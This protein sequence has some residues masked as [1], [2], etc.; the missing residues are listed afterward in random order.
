[1]LG[2]LT[3]SLILL[4]K[5]VGPIFYKITNYTIDIAIL[6]PYYHYL[7]SKAIFYEDWKNRSDQ[8]REKTT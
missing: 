8:G 1:M 7:C 5:P 2:M 6:V 4:S 3:G